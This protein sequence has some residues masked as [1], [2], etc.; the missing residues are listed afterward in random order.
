MEFKQES[1][2][3]S[4]LMALTKAK[5]VKATLEETRQ[6]EELEDLRAR[7]LKNSARMAAVNAKRKREE[8]MLAQARGEVEA[9]REN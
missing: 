9:T 5:P 1:E 7:S 6:I 2:I 4:Q 8:N 3:L